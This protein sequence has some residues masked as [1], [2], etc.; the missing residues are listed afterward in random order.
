MAVKEAVCDVSH[1]R[2][3]EV[4]VRGLR[5]RNRART[6]DDIIAAALDLFE[7]K[8]F[9]AT[10]TEDIAAAAGVSPRTFFR[11][12]DTKLDVVMAAKGGEAEFDVHAALL[13]RPADESPIA[14]L[15]N[16]IGEPMRALSSGDTDLVRQYCIMMATPSLRAL[17]LEHFHEHEREIAAAFAERLGRKPDDLGAKM[18]AAA[19]GAALRT[20]FEQWI[21]A[22]A[23]P[24][25]LWPVVDQALTMLERGFG[26]VE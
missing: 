9:D 24:G 20:A 11:Y 14:A 23:K 19:V 6:H 2:V 5:E 12:F 13:A 26:S 3:G 25:R 21:G 16:V 18:M 22:C 7:T 1:S 15:R 17:Q 10:T 8:G 4:S